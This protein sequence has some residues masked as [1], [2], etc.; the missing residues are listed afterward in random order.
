MSLEKQRSTLLASIDAAISHA[1]FI[2]PN[3]GEDLLTSIIPSIAN[4]KYTTGGKM[5]RM[6]MLEYEREV[7]GF[8]LSEHPALQLKKNYE[9]KFMNA[10]SISTMKDRENMTIIGL[11]TEIKRIRTKKGESM[12]FVSVQDETGTV[13]CTFFPRNYS[14]SNLLLKEMAMIRIEGTVEKRRGKPQ[15][16]VQKAYKV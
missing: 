9:G 11:I 16:L 12:A 3:D 4:P 10:S 2:G 1:M 15:I 7:L 13:S 14:E 5:P 8:Y 6:V